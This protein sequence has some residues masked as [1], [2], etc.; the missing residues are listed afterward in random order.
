MSGAPGPDP[1]A[2][3]DADRGGNA[4]ADAQPSASALQAAAGLDAAP[5]PDPAP[6]VP[7]PVAPHRLRPRRAQA[8]SAMLPICGAFALCPPFILVF[9]RP[10]EAFGLPLILFYLG[11]VWVGLIF[12]AW[13]LSWRLRRRLTLSAPPRPGLPPEPRA[14]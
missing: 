9:A 5:E 2:A 12:G 4:P 1:E 13:R 8:L 7:P 3:P 11:A 6:P 10:A 14:S